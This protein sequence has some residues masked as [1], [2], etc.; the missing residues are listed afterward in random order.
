MADQAR[1]EKTEGMKFPR[2]IIAIT[3]GVLLLGAGGCG[4]TTAKRLN[5]NQVNLAE[6]IHNLEKE[7]KLV[8]KEGGGSITRIDELIAKK[9]EELK[10]SQEG[11]QEKPKHVTT[12]EVNLGLDRQTIAL[13]VIKCIHAEQQSGDAGTVIGGRSEKEDSEVSRA[14]RELIAAFR[15]TPDA[16][17]PS[18]ENPRRSVRTYLAEEAESL[19][20]FCWPWLA[21]EIRTVLTYG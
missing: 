4:G 13:G 2:V 20:K 21:R 11:S 1:L 7:K 16:I 18:D 17:W 5:A 19:Q 3:V 10:G 14:V 8:E 15:K 9:Q 12:E 6:E